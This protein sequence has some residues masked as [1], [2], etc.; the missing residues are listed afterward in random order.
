MIRKLL[1]SIVALLGLSGVVMAGPS[2][3]DWEI[4]FTNA[5]GSINRVEDSSTI[6]ALGVE[7]G[8]FLT[9]RHEI[10]FGA[11]Y[12]GIASRNDTIDVQ[13]LYR[14]NLAMAVT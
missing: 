1:F 13:G 5:G 4:M 14:Y 2:E 10:G 8:Y 12:R 11:T 7:A 9:A 3:G 6:Y